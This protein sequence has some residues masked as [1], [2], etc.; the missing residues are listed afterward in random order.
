MTDDKHGDDR[1]HRALEDIDGPLPPRPTSAI[2]IDWPDGE[3][4]VALRVLWSVDSPRRYAYTHREIAA[5]LDGIHPPTLNATGSTD[6]R[7]HRHNNVEGH[8]VQDSVEVSFRES[9][10][11]LSH[12]VAHLRRSIDIDSGVQVDQ[13]ELDQLKRYSPPRGRYSWCV[14]LFFGTDRASESPAPRRALKF[15]SATAASAEDVWSFVSVASALYRT[16]SSLAKLERTEPAS[17]DEPKPPP[18]NSVAD[19]LNAAVKRADWDSCPAL[20]DEYEA[21]LRTVGAG[22][23][24]G[25]SLLALA[26]AAVHERRD[27]AERAIELHQKAW[28]GS[29]SGREAALW[30]EAI[31][32]K[33]PAAKE[34]EVEEIQPAS[35]SPAP[36]RRQDC[37]RQTIDLVM[38]VRAASK[39][40]ERCET[41]QDW[42]GCAKALDT[43][44]RLLGS[45]AEMIPQDQGERLLAFAEATIR[46]RADQSQ[47]AIAI[48]L[49]AWPSG[50][51]ESDESQRAEAVLAR[52]AL[53]AAKAA[54]SEQAK[55]RPKGAQRMNDS[56]GSAQEADAADR[57]G[58]DI[59]DLDED[60]IPVGHQGH[61]ADGSDGRPL[62]SLCSE[63]D[64]WSEGVDDNP[65]RV[66]QA[67]IDLD[68][69]PPGE[70]LQDPPTHSLG[71]SIKYSVKGLVDERTGLAMVVGFLIWSWGPGLKF[72]GHPQL[73][74]IILMAGLVL[75]VR[76]CIYVSSRR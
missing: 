49:R 32:S 60:W 15:T 19:Q 8:A 24:G 58:D 28:P 38:Q 31:P 48:Y 55:A 1:V 71:D 61:G 30:L 16:L 35:D 42:T 2:S 37:T 33:Q 26:Q 41:N 11:V 65:T 40:L 59:G 66:D 20:L 25:A 46:T 18:A 75:V 29:Q 39:R 43:L 22:S 51:S 44:R 34:A 74:L 64:V 36:A 4:V 27:L 69:A 54:R 21:R 72:T 6:T 17:S 76:V 13:V 68:D 70:V 14:V 10:P 52:H 5:S 45:S 3:N 67:P 73:D 56:T 12:L 50:P 23:T 9:R 53:A 57:A 7:L 47:V 63:D 62:S